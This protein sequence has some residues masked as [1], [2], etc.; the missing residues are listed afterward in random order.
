MLAIETKFLLLRTP[1]L[2]QAE[3]VVKYADLSLNSDLS[4][5]KELSGLL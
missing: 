4:V 1:F 5:I 3:T 2:S